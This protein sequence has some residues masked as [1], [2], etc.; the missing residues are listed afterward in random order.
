[1]WPTTVRNTAF[2][3]CALFGRMGGILATLTV[4]LASYY[5]DL[6]V[7]LYGSSTIVAA[8]LLFAFLPETKNLKKLPDSIEETI[9]I[10][11]NRID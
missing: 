8:I 2:N 7:L 1:M 11:R 6:P 9:N 5:A 10:G 4:L 3:I